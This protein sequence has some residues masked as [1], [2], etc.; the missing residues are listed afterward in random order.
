VELPET[1]A[2]P[3]ETTG[4]DAQPAESAA[5]AQPRRR[6]R[7][8]RRR[9]V[10]E[11]PTAAEISASDAAVAAS[12]AEDSRLAAP[13]GVEESSPEILT[14]DHEAAAESV[15][16]IGRTSDN[17]HGDAVAETDTPVAG[18]ATRRTRR[19]R[20]SARSAEAVAPTDVPDPGKPAESE[21]QP[22]PLPNE[23]EMPAAAVVARGD[24]GPP[25]RGWWSRFVRKEE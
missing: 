22:A 16:G 9:A 13:N 18:P 11:R 10:P 6:T 25:R 20:T 4:A 19:R 21:Q 24:A 3:F 14:S 12:G 8:R 1:Q 5:L 15:A 7:T 2:P 23:P 17:G